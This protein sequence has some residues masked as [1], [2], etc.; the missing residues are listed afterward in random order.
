MLSAAIAVAVAFTVLTA[1]G[2]GQAVNGE[3]QREREPR[4]NVHEQVQDGGRA[5]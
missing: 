1:G 4:M 2:A 3:Q 5:A